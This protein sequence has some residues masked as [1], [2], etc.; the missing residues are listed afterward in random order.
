MVVMPGFLPSIDQYVQLTRLKVLYTWRI[1]DCVNF[2]FPLL[3]R[4]G[5]VII[6]MKYSTQV[7]SCLLVKSGTLPS[8]DQYVHFTRLK[9]V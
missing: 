5:P 2:R 6:R 1:V 9:H 7:L 4:S 3:E 8:I